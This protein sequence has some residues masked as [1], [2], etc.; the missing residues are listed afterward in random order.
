MK[1]QLS[2]NAVV[3][4]SRSLQQKNPQAWAAATTAPKDKVKMLE[5][6]LTDDQG[7]ECVFTFPLRGF[8]GG[9]FGAFLSMKGEAKI[10]VQDATVKVDKDDAKLQDLTAELLG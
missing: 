8:K 9:S 3:I 1:I 6:H 2:A 7:Q 5:V 4:G 10:V